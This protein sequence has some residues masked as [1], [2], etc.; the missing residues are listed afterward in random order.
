MEREIINTCNNIIVMLKALMH[1]DVAAC[2]FD[3][4]SDVKR[5]LNDTNVF[6]L[7]SCMLDF[8]KFICDFVRKQIGRF[9][10]SPSSCMN[11]ICSYS[12]SFEQIGVV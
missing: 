2:P 11:I 5:F 1:D 12:S 9:V 8:L 10:F 4:A 7:S 6:N 3:S